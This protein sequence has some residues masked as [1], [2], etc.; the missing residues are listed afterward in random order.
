MRYTFGT[1]VNFLRHQVPEDPRVGWGASFI[2]SKISTG[3]W[4]ETALIPCAFSICIHD[5]HATA[6]PC[7]V[8]QHTDE[9]AVMLPLQLPALRC[10]HA[11][12]KP[13]KASSQNYRVTSS[14]SLIFVIQCTLASKL[15]P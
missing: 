4:I 8:H 13:L 11:R 6:M 7:N 1:F 10:A 3:S 9:F 12:V 15:E 14:F 2:Y 5:C